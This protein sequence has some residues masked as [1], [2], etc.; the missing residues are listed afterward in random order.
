VVTAAVVAVLSYFN[1]IANPAGKF[2]A[3][4]NPLV[5]GSTPIIQSVAEH[6]PATWGSFF[7][8][9]GTTIFLT[10]FGF[11]FM[12]QRARNDD[13]FVILW[14][15]TS[16]YFAAS[17]VRLTL[18]MA[19]AFCILAGIG[20]VEL[21]KPAVDIIREAVIYPRRKTHAIARIGREFGVAIF[22][23]L[24]IVIAPTFWTAV[25]AS[26]QPATIVTSS[27]PAVPAA[28]NEL[29]YTD[30]LQA[31]SWMR[32]NTPPSSVVFAWW[33]YGYWI[34]ALGDRR[35]LA[36]NGTQN[37]TQIAI[38]AQTFLSNATFAIPT[39]KRYNVSYVAIFVT[40]S[41]SGSQTKWQGYG[42]DG[43]WYWMARIG[44]NTMWNNYQVVFTEQTN[45]QA[46]TSTYNRLIM[47]G[48]KV[49]ANETIADSTNGPTENTLLGYMMTQVTNQAGATAGTQTTN[50]TFPQLTEVFSS[51]NNFVFI[52]KVSYPA[53]TLLTFSPIPSPITYGQKVLIEGNLTDTSGNPLSVTPVVD[54]EY[55][56]DMGATWNRVDEILV[57]A[58]GS[59]NYTWI[60][61]AGNYTVRVHYPGSAGVYLESVS[62]QS[63][64]VN[65]ANVALAV[66]ASTTGPALGQNV[67]LNWQMSPFAPRANL[68]LSYTTDN[69]TFVRIT[70]VIMTAP[71]MNYTWKDTV[72][73]T[74]RIV[75]SIAGD[76]N[77]NPA[78]ASVE[79]KTA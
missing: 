29:K 26:Y 55:S 2:Y 31:L 77:F 52:F 19:P 27:I 78:V 42:E 60:P 40:P 49:L 57:N 75:V 38:I 22:L 47:N 33:D 53:E 61:N 43:K 67:T 28:G 45:V 54:I 50:Q 63:L 66:A 76:N 73:G 65:K 16:V 39:L 9:F 5:R 25:Q 15:V 32:E 21:G 24:L 44:N 59:F 10:L 71:S 62:E 3:V 13:I 30:W 68:T 6:Q 20:T 37:S 74:F 64:V 56:T 69:M 41:G 51:T 58:N 23:I 36:D 79:M 48:T 35:S 11:I 4:I 14:G 1:I 72:S 12:F 46:Q 17:F 7:Y 18:L 8:E 70:S 34:T